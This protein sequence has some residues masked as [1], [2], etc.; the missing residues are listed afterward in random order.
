MSD[1]IVRATA[2]DAGIR[3][4]AVNAKEMVETA[5]LDH[6]TS[7]IMTAALGRLLAAG[8]M[9]G[10]MMKGEKDVLTLQIQ[11]SG[12]AKGLTVTADSKGNVKGFVAN[13]VVDLPPNAEG[14]LNVGG[15]LDLGVLS[16]IK[17]MGLKEPYVGQCQ[18]QTG[19]IAEDLTYYFATSEQVPSAVGLG[20]LVDKNGVKQAGGFIIQLM[21]FTDD[22]V[23]EKLE[24]KISEMESVTNM[25]ERGLSPEGILEEILGD[26]GLEITDTL[27]TR[28]YCDCSKEKVSRAL[29]SINKKD[30]DDI[31]NDGESIEVKCQFCNKA[32]S[33]D[34]DELKEIRKS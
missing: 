26:L 32:Y 9:M 8:A 25:L 4:F 21:P 15:A 24:K 1:Y 10:S 7:P 30:L 31:I 13:P 34:V 18:L 33:F 5:R 2:A 27:D 22:E 11:C 14:K 3:A 23:I 20:V 16:V 29:A 28:F 19:E 12:P 17:D 6:G